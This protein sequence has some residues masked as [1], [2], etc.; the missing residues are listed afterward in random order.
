[1]RV[2][3][4]FACALVTTSI[5][6]IA[7]QPLNLEITPL[8]GYRFGGDFNTSRDAVHNKIELS[9]E[10]SYG[11]LTS[12]S[13]DPK[14]K[15]EFLI[16]HYETSFSEADDFIASNT[17]LSITYAHIGGTVPIS[18]G[19]VPFYATGGLGLVHFSPEDDN[20]NDE[21]RFSMNV[22]LASK[23]YLTENISFRI[24]GRAYA[25]FF[26]SE[27]NIFCDIDTCTMYL[28]SEMWFQTEVSAGIG[29][30]F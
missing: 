16:S 7:A 21:T 6:A 15:G 24:D 26:N 18:E 5:P 2:T 4:A 27:S 25:T 13:V 14:R 30:R 3:L 17:P 12:W 22:G 11:L 8:I 28:S 20:L 19:V 23:V 1:M 10:T 9:E 29:Y